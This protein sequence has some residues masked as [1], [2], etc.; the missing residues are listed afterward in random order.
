M[1]P[2]AVQTYR[3]L[4][5]GLVGAV[6]LLATSILIERSEVDCWQTSI[7]GYYYTPVRAIFVGML[8][9]VGF[10]LIVIKGRTT[11]VDVALNFAGMLAPLVAVA[12]TTNVGTC[13]SVDPPASPL[14]PD[15]TLAGWVVANID[16]N[17][18]ALLATGIVGLVAWLV[19]VAATGGLGAIAQAGSTSLR[20]GLVATAVFIAV[21]WAAFRFWDD[22]DERA[23]A[24]AA[25]TFFV[26]LAVAVLLN[27]RE[28]RGVPGKQVFF[29][30]YLAVFVA[31]V[32]A[33]VPLLFS[34]WE[35]N[36]LI[37]E[38]VE[39][40]LF[41]VFWAVQT[42]ELWDTTASPPPPP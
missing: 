13:W 19:I 41:A 1:S 7:S 38:A 33:A 14:N 11:W 20:L 10:A 34:G 6:V 17:V 18:A 2:A 42:V 37:V 16:N 15:G 26:F 27:A 39:I 31:M 40:L 29:V 22:F 4:R 8:I 24:L 12:P 36:V 3:Y 25:V 30:L 23:H 32:V 21:V 5:I 28:V 9:T 35:H